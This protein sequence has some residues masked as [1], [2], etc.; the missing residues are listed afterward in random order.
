MTLRKAS[1]QAACIR[2]HRLSRNQIC[3][4]QAS[5]PAD[6]L[7]SN[8]S[9]ILLAVCIYISFQYFA[10]LSHLPVIDGFGLWFGL[11]GNL[12]FCFYCMFRSKISNLVLMMYFVEKYQ[13]QIQ[14]RAMPGNLNFNSQSGARPKI[15]NSNS[16]R[17]SSENFKFKSHSGNGISVC[18][19][20]TTIKPSSSVP[21]SLMAIPLKYHAP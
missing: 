3:K 17:Q 5:F 1:F 13:I 15:S 2:S 8:S 16:V 21:S 20:G 19:S 12:K 18:P 9:A 4:R 7:L 14:S 6:I 11:L 10:S